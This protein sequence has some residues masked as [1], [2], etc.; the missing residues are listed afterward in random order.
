MIAGYRGGRFDSV[1]GRVVDIMMALP[2]FLVAITVLAVLGPGLTNAM[3]AVGILVTRRSSGSRGRPPRTCGRRPTSRRRARWGARPVASWSA[4]CFPNVLAPVVVQIAILLGVAITIEASLS[5]LG[6][7]VQPPTS[8]WGSMLSTANSFMTQAPHLMYVPGAAIAITVL[9]F[10][11][12]GDGLAQALGTT[13]RSPGE[14]AAW[15]CSRSTTSRS[16]SPAGRVGSTRSRVCRSRS[17]RV[18]P[19]AWSAS[20]VRARRSPPSPCSA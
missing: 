2:G 11:L 20:P 4:T 7:G 15:R 1:I 10:S 19:S 6:L 9:A 18:R 13:Q 12:L 16:R 3:I 14:V 17:S 5:F 8:T